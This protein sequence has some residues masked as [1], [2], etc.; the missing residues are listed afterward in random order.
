M[1]WLDR[2]VDGM[3]TNN[4]RPGMVVQALDAAAAAAAVLCA[5]VVTWLRV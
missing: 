3:S 2:E 1:C 5:I 4:L